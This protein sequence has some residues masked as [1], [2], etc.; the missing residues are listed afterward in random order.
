MTK[1]LAKNK[2]NFH[3]QGHSANNKIDGLI[4]FQGS[5]KLF[6]CH[7]LTLQNCQSLSLAMRKERRQK[8]K[9]A[10]CDNQQNNKGERKEK[11]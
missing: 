3:A 2:T 5:I 1:T 8:R 9:R 4:L 6:P 7:Y 10:V 11:T